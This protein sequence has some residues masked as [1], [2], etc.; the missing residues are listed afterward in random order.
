M[1]R[2]KIGFRTPSLSKS[3]AA[4]MSP[5]RFLRHNLGL[6]APGGWGFATDPA[7]ALYNRVYSRLTVGLSDV[8]RALLRR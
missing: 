7:K 4:R 5:A 3:L 2:F 1:K 6:K 8:I